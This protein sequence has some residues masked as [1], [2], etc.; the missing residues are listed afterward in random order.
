MSKV[1]IVTNGNDIAK[2]FEQRADAIDY[3]GNANVH[4]RNLQLDLSEH[5][6]IA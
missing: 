1:Y 5:Q 4:K 2:V 6:L 3:I